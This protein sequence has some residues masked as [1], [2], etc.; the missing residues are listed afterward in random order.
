MGATISGA[1]GDVVVTFDRLLKTRVGLPAN[2]L[3]RADR[4][5][6]PK[7]H[8]PQPPV[9]ITGNEA[10]IPTIPGGIAFPPLGVTYNAAPPN[11]E[12]RPGVA[13]APFAKFPIVT[14]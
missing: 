11:V 3:I 2:W 14:V 5:P 1:T 7:T 13:A 8:A 9:T 4:G 10:R 6:G 12:S